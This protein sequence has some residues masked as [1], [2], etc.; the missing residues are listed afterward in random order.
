MLN[1]K[2]YYV[3]DAKNKTAKPLEE[4]RQAYNYR[5]LI[6][7]LLRRDIV[8]RYK[9]SFLGIGWT[10]LNPLGTMIVLS[11]AFSQV[12]KMTE[13]YPAYVLSGLMAWNFFSQTTYASMVNL[14]WGGGLLK[15]IY[16]PRTSF[17]LAAVGTGVVNTLLTIIPMI[18]VML[19]LGV[20]VKLTIFFIPIP[21]L[22]LALFSLGFGLILS[23]LAV[24]FPDVAEMYQIVLTAWMYLTPIIYPEEILPENIHFIISTFNPMYGL[25]KLFRI[26]IYYGRLPS[27]EEF[28]FPAL[29]AVIVFIIGWL[30]FTYRSDEFAYKI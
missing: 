8:T 18:I 5:Y 28:L 10:M 9:R 4:L 15:R 14:V 26:P 12:F 22:L 2:N 24:Y 13:G 3:Y 23:T 17:A 1:N 20:P 19:V 11:I 25:V 29:L 16:M 7:Q 21:L 6:S 30:F 27:I